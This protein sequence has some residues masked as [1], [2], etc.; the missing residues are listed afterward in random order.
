MATIL[1]I[2]QLFSCSL[3]SWCQH[4][5]P[6]LFVHTNHLFPMFIQPLNNSINLILRATAGFAP[7]SHPASSSFGGGGGGVWEIIEGIWRS[8][9]F[10]SKENKHFHT[11][12]KRP[13]SMFMHADSQ[14][15]FG[16]SPRKKVSSS[17]IFSLMFS[18]QCNL[19]WLLRLL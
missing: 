18:H 8:A 14:A 13:S 17:T 10:T 19:P 4:K 12:L 9:F 3:S 5:F 1:Q 7:P 16:F 11:W 2:T 6:W 15:C